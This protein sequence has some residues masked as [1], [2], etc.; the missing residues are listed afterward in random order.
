MRLWFFHSCYRSILNSSLC[1]YYSFSISEA[2]K[3]NRRNFCRGSSWLSHFQW[4]FLMGKLS[5][6]SLLHWMELGNKLSEQW[7]P[8]ELWSKYLGMEIF[9][10][11]LCDFFV[12]FPPGLLL[13]FE[14]WWQMPLIKRNDH[15]QI[16]CIY[17]SKWNAPSQNCLSLLSSTE[18]GVMSS[19]LWKHWS[20]RCLFHKL[21]LPILS[22]GSIVLRPQVIRMLFRTNNKKRKNKMVCWAQRPLN[23]TISCKIIYYST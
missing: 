13:T 20:W 5:T 7:K 22:V 2:G 21:K 4:R 10:S 11:S 18:P 17:F 6:W 23:F 3:L 16:F 9:F 8:K 15:L 19:K 12:T 1:K 14:H